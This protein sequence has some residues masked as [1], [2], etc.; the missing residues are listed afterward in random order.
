LRAW[1]SLISIQK[2]LEIRWKMRNLYKAI[3]LL[4]ITLAL[5]IV[6]IWGFPAYLRGL[7]NPVEEHDYIIF[8]DDTSVKAKNGKNGA[9]DLSS[10]NASTVMNQ[11]IAQGNNVYI[12]FGEYTLSSDILVHNKKNARIIGSNASIICN[13]K[14]VIIKGDNYTSSQNNILSGLEIVNGTLRIENSFKATISDMVFRN[15]TTA[16]ELVNTETWSECTTIEDC[17]FIDSLISIVF[18]TPID[19]GTGFYA[20]TEIS[21]CCFELSVIIRWACGSSRTQNSRA[22]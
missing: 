5:V 18:K 9:I 13:G 21:R 7:Y 16:I 22:V 20:N 17:Y 1:R 12:K 8:Q 2:N 19:P 14:K 10:T 11:A 15:C 6:G 4:L 3:L